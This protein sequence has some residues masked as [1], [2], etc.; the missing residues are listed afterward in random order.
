M[1]SHKLNQDGY[2]RKRWGPAKEQVAEMFHRT[3]YQHH[4]GAIPEGYDIDHICKKR[5]CCNPKH[6]RIFKH[7]DH[8]AYTNRYR[9]RD[10]FLKAQEYWKNTQCTGI[11]LGETFG[12][13]FST[14]ANWIK[15]FKKEVQT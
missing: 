11:H 10:R 6:L 1:K 4:H 9:Y 15:Q 3:M 8:Q 13:S 7:G 2:F 14:G 12:V 5:N